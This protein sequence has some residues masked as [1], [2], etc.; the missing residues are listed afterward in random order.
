MKK[1]IVIAVMAAMVMPAF[2]EYLATP[3]MGTPI[4]LGQEQIGGPQRGTVVYSSTNAVAG[5]SGHNGIEV[6]DEV[7]ADKSGCPGCDT[8]DSLSWT[9]YNS[10]AAT[11]NLNSVDCVVRIYDTGG[12]SNPDA[13]NL[14]GELDFG[15][16]APALAPGWYTV[17]SAS[18][19]AQYGLCCPDIFTITVELTT[20]D[21]GANPGQIIATPPS[22]GSSGDYFWKGGAAPGW[23]WFGGSPVADLYYEVDCVPEPAG[24]LLLGLGVAL[25]RRR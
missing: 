25:I 1:L 18:D 2:A 7:W 14:C 16:L 12:V 10:S 22:I 4:L 5:A 6:G 21:T 9:V 17:Y 8:L 15:T 20:T 23:Y 11:G 19:L 24:L 13:S 3:D